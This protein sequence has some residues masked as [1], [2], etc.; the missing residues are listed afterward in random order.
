M[1]AAGHPT[2]N[3]PAVPTSTPPIS[4][5]PATPLPYTATQ[6]SQ[7]GS[8][9]MADLT[10]LPISA[11]A[12]LAQS[13][14]DMIVA[15][16]NYAAANLTSSSTFPFTSPTFSSTQV[17][18]WFT[19]FA[20]RN[21][22]G[23]LQVYNPTA[24]ISP[25][26]TPV[27]GATPFP[28]DQAFLSRRQLLQLRSSI[29]GTA[30][31]S[32][33]PASVL[34]YMGTFSRG[35]E[36][37]SYVPAHIRYP[38]NSPTGA[39]EAP[40]VNTLMGVASSGSTPGP[41][42]AMPGE[43]AY[44]GNNDAYSAAGVTPSGQD[45][46]NPSLLSI[47]VTQAFTRFDPY[48]TP[49][50]IGEPLLKRKF[51]L[52]RLG[53]MSYAATNQT[54]SITDPNLTFP[55]SSAIPNNNNHIYDW[56]GLSRTSASAPWTY[57][58]GAS[59]PH[60]MTLEEVRDAAVPREPDFA[61][62]LKA[63]INVGSLAKGGPNLNVS[64]TANY[65]YVLDT[66][67]DYQ[68]LQI[69]AN[70]IDQYDTDSYPTVIQ[71]ASGSLMRT[72][73]GVE[74]LP[75]F[76]RYH[77]FSVVTRQ[78]NP[79][80]PASSNSVAFTVAAAN[81][82]T[83]T[84][85]N[86][87]TCSPCA[88][89]ESHPSGVV[90]GGNAVALYIPEVWNPHDASTRLSANTKR[91]TRF[92][93]S[94]ITDDPS[95]PSPQTAVW[96]T[97]MK[98]QMNQ[99][100][101]DDI[102]PKSSIPEVVYGLTDPATG[103]PGTPGSTN[104]T[105]FTFSDDSGKLF[106]EPTLLWRNSY[107]TNINLI[108]DTGSLAGP[109]KDVN[110]GISYYGVQIGQSPISYQGTVS[111]LTYPASP[112]SASDKYIFQAS[113]A[114]AIDTQPATSNIQYTFRLQYQDP[115]NSSNWI[116]YDEKYPDIHGLYQS[117]LVVNQADF[118]N[119]SWWN[120]LRTRQ[121]SD[122]ATGS[123]PRSARF[124]IGTASGFQESVMPQE[125]TAA[126]N[127][128]NSS[129]AGN[130]AL[131]SS[132]FTVFYTQRAFADLGNQV[133]YSNPGMTSNTNGGRSM[134][135][136]WFSGRGFNAAANATGA[137]S[138]PL[139][140]DGI[141]FGQND[142]SVYIPE[143]GSPS[144]L[145]QHLYYEDADGVA[146]RAMGAYAYSYGTSAMPA[147]GSASPGTGGPAATPVNYEGLPLAAADT[148]VNGDVSAGGASV[149]NLSRPLMLNRPFRSV[150]EMSYASRGEPWKQI[151]FFTPES[152]DSALL[153]MFC[154]NETPADGMVAGKVSLN[155]HQAP[156]LQAIV[157]QSTRDELANY[158]YPPSYSETAL[159]GAE[160]A[161]VASKLVSI[162][163]DLTD[164]WRGPLMSV[165]DLVGHYV[166]TT[167]ATTATDLYTFNETVTNKA[168]N[169]AGLSPGLF[170]IPSSGATA[171]QKQT[172]RIQRLHESAIRALSDSG[173]TR[174]WNL[175]IDV[176]AQTG[177][178]TPNAMTLAQFAVDGESRYWVHVAI[179]RYTGEVIDKQ[180]EV[181]SQ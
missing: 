46:I 58:H 55:P 121:M 63:A 94:V 98:P 103:S 179:D 18:N 83:G 163:T 122:T 160:A 135:M 19:N 60:V 176:V 101:Y 9:A 104:L 52:S 47:R 173:Q 140:Y 10:Q 131:G 124:G 84:A 56:F 35:L 148:I 157:A 89:L 33:F 30:S 125:S 57:N 80:L 44:V 144:T 53:E 2:P 130:Q 68:V 118:T 31:P 145:D 132:N 155:T 43:D 12:T 21:T 64:N 106:R 128:N 24:G 165:G 168:Y 54:Q 161:T 181:V 27:P 72:F 81:P 170:P 174:V 151:D 167:P 134:E 62:L 93:L 82:A 78:P 75:Y 59:T 42:P 28:T 113:A 110:T 127:Y 92:R 166:N 50:V 70:L 178:Y 142:P 11:T 115:N 120:P 162:T 149:Q 85:A 105:S 152:G 172:Y 153:D 90:D 22:N 79:L 76:Y 99:D 137:A 126:S 107:P 177:R 156:V 143:R 26:P 71:I 41:P 36:Q 32:I 88:T 111:H 96:Q 112:Q 95:L 102:P 169:Y 34:Q 171:L 138:W 29:N 117:T 77:P 14:I 147:E 116:T 136:R 180:I 39:Q 74:D 8:L 61:E 175:M 25:T 139:E 15:W 86:I 1:N 108:P 67:V 91:P 7:K 129:T 6:V 17:A 114:Q 13:T 159:T 51:A 4:T 45:L 16:R 141:L 123:D 73:R 66:A 100:W 38:A 5:P 119:S 133:N 164:A 40:N 146:R 48:Q 49:A 158:Q 69:M 20:F 87:K 23:F 109:Y 37:P 3:T 65:Q 154:V 97:G 150:A